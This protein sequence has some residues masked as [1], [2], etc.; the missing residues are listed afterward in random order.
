MP[1][2]T[3]STVWPTVGFTVGRPFHLFAVGRTSAARGGRQGSPATTW[4]RAAP[5]KSRRSTSSC[6]GSVC[7]PAVCLPAVC[8]PAPWL[9]ALLLPAFC[10]PAICCACQLPASP[11]RLSV[12]LL[13]AAGSRCRCRCRCL[14]RLRRPPLFSCPQGGQHCARRGAD[15]AGRGAPQLLLGRPLEHPGPVVWRLLLV[16]AGWLERCW[17]QPSHW[18]SAWPS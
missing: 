16:G 10:V 1:Q 6:S 11:A 4:R 13:P 5:H 8:L 7:L 3:Q 18:C 14:C 9:P 15:S 2:Q 12:Y 17:V